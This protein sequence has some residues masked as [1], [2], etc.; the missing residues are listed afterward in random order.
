VQRVL[1]VHRVD[2]LVLQVRLDQQVTRGQ[3]VLL[4]FEVQQVQLAR[5]A[6]IQLF[7][8]LL[9]LEDRQVHRVKLVQ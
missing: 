2:R 8:V 3:L 1:L 6:Q 9:A 4:V 5:L 7:L